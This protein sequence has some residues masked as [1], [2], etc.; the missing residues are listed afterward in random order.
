MKP[1]SKIYTLLFLLFLFPKFTIAQDPESAWLMKKREP[2]KEKNTVNQ[3]I[4]KY[5]LKKM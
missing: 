3:N 5:V 1:N 4:V 2:I